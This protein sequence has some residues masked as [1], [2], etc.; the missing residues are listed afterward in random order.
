MEVSR[1]VLPSY[2]IRVFRES[3]LKEPVL[4]TG[5][6]GFGGIGTEVAKMLVRETEANKIAEIFS[7]YFP[8]HVI[9]RSDGTCRLPS[10]R[11][12][13][14]SAVS[15]NLLILTGDYQPLP[16]NVHVHYELCRQVLE[17]A[18]SFQVRYIL[19]VGGFPVPNKLIMDLL[20]ARL[21]EDVESGKRIFV[22]SSSEDLL[23]ELVKQGA[24]IYRQGRIYGATGLIVGLAKEEGIPAA[25]VLG[26]T[27]QDVLAP[28]PDREASVMVFNF[29]VRFLGLK[30]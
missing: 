27:F 16:E 8:D 18:K 7:P 24:A 1:H 6:P 12:Y 30:T 4:V 17:L 28:T 23:K 25:A 15:P 10:Y 11:V 3:K 5:L 22:A 13:A 29:L 26:V 2:E 9:I 19:T 20:P 21:K 14:S